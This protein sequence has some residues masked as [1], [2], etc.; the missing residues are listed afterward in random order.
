MRDKWW[1][2]KMV[3]WKRKQEELPQREEARQISKETGCRRPTVKFRGVG[4]CVECLV[5]LEGRHKQCL[6]V[7]DYIPTGMNAKSAKREKHALTRVFYCWELVG[8]E[9]L[10]ARATMAWEK[11]LP[12]SWSKINLRKWNVSELCETV[13]L[14]IVQ[15]SGLQIFTMLKEVLHLQ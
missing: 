13:F 8:V 9:K 14:L 6:C 5:G 4:V 15:M 12:T 1:G 2:V 11:P 10:F 3:R 7:P